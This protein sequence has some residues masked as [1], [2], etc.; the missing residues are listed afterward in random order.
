M[1][2]LLYPHAKLKLMV[3]GVRMMLDIDIVKSFISLVLQ[4]RTT[5]FVLRLRYET[6]SLCA[7][8]L[9]VLTQSSFCSP[10]A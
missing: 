1:C 10:V 5:T 8:Y 6:F 9:V 3:C 7:K 2:D 4:D